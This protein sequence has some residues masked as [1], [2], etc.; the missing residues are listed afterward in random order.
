MV[1]GAANAGSA[2]L[3]FA[4]TAAFM[5]AGSHAADQLSLTSTHV[6]VHTLSRKDRIKGL[7]SSPGA[8]VLT[9]FHL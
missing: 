6:N 7:G 2:R 8:V 1:T 3:P 9:R 4:Q 5:Q